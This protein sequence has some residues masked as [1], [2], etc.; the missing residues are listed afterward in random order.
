MCLSARPHGWRQPD[1]DPIVAVRQDEVVVLVAG[2]RRL[3][4]QCLHHRDAR[5]RDPPPCHVLGDL[6]D[7]VERATD[8]PAAHQ[9]VVTKAR[10]PDVRHCRCVAHAQ[11]RS[12]LAPDVSRLR[13]EPHADEDRAYR[14]KRGGED[15]QGECPTAAQ[16]EGAEPEELEHPQRPRPTNI[17]SSARSSPSTPSPNRQANDAHRGGLRSARS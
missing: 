3:P 11:K 9:A 5:D 4:G 14:A 12:E 2:G 1:L 17:E 13:A 7:G 6:D 16:I 8:D 10:G 15:R